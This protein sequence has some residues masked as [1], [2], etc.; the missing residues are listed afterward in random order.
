MIEL[1]KYDKTDEVTQISRLL[2]DFW[3]FEMSVDYASIIAS[4]LSW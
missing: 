3:R 1:R 2:I 4:L